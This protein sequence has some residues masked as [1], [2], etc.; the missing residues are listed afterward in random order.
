MSANSSQPTPRAG[1]EPR[2]DNY[3]YNPVDS[4]NRNT[5]KGA[6]AGTTTGNTIVIHRYAN[7]GI[8]ICFFR[9]ES[10]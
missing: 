10:S 8:I 1:Q 9:D 6:N 2:Q 7:P 3:S 5:N 4:H